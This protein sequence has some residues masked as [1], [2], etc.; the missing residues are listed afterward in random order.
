M[1]L[2]TSQKMF[3]RVL[4]TSDQETPMVLSASPFVPHT[5]PYTVLCLLRDRGALSR[6]DL[7]ERV[8][9][10]RARTLAEIDTL[11]SGALVR[12]AG[13][14]ASRGGRRSTLVELSPDIR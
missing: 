9:E 8:G 7:A 14:A 1:N 2:F 3:L 12:E 4:P 6:A 5:I 13:L 11:V 10:P